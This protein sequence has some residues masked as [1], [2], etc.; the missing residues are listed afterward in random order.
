M[1]AIAGAGLT[2]LSAACS[3]EGREVAVYEREREPGGLCR[4]LERDGFAFDLTG[5]LLHLRR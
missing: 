4:T 2:G 5:H 1:I 3:L